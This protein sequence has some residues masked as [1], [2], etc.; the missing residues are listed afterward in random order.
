MQYRRQFL[1][2]L[3]KNFDLEE[4]LSSHRELARD[5]MCIPWFRKQMIKLQLAR[6]IFSEPQFTEISRLNQETIAIFLKVSQ[7]LISRAK[8]DSR[9]HNPLADISD[10]G[11]PSLISP[12]GSKKL[13][14]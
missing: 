1:A 11:Q 8:A 14:Q 13:F 7:P 3:A 5:Q 6:S 4:L 12:E 9:F 10:G 2:F